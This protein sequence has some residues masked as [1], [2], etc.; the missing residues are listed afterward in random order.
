ML[1]GHF[2]GRFLAMISKLIKP[3]SILEIGTYTGYSALCLAEGLQADGKLITI[4]INP[5]LEEVIHK[6]IQMA[7]M[8][9]KI[10][11]IVG[12]A[13]Q[14]IRTLPQNFD[15]VFINWKKMKSLDHL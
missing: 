1:S 2:Q 5:E 15:L 7:K 14:V 6:H 3:K 13:Y 12:D 11:F 10:Q 4:D 8:E 9:D